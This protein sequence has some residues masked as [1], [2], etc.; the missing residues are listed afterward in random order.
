MFMRGRMADIAKMRE[1]VRYFRD[2]A[3]WLRKTG[4]KSNPGD[5]KL[6]QRFFELAAECDAIA[7]K[8]EQNIDS[9]IHKP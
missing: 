1:R 8:I 3:K 7:D 6:R 4:G 9:G 2:Q 5:P